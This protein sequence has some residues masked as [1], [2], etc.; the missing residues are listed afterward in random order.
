VILH[1]QDNT[2]AP[3][4]TVQSSVLGTFDRDGDGVAESLLRQRFDTEYFFGRRVETL[5]WNGDK[6]DAEPVQET[7]PKGF[8]VT[9]SEMADL[10]GNGKAETAIVKNGFLFIYRGRKQIYKSPHKLGG[11]IVSLN[12]N[13]TPGMQDS[14]VDTVRFE[15]SPLWCDIDHDGRKELIVPAAEGVNYILTGL[16]TEVDASWLAVVRREQ[17]RFS[18]KELSETFERPIQGLG[19]SPQGVLFLTTQPAGDEAEH[20]QATVYRLPIQATQ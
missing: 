14:R 18:T 5:R 17:G 16:P 1:W 11:S 3:V 13:A 6:L 7:L 10:D 20:G 19:I 12:Y 4:A 8:R 15:L 9:G 2:L